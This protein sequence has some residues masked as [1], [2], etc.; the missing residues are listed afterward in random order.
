MQVCTPALQPPLPAAAESAGA[1]IVSRTPQSM[2]RAS[3]APTTAVLPQALDLVIHT[4]ARHNIRLG[5]SLA[6]YHTSFG[7]GQ[8]GIEPYVQWVHQTYN[9]T[10]AQG[11]ALVCARVMAWHGCTFSCR[12]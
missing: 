1:A 5:L 9:L 3:R 10:G 12:Q 2:C 8:A 6:D 7:S 4:A 11:A